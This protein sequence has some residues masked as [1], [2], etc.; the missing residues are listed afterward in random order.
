M[1]TVIIIVTD[2]GSMM[3]TKV[4]N[5]P[6][7]SRHADSSSS[8]G[9]LKE[10]TE[11]EDEQ[12]VLIRKT[13]NGE[14]VERPVSVDHVDRGLAACDVYRVNHTAAEELHDVENVEVSEL[15]EE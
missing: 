4:L 14:N 3:L 2:R 12:S 6:A 10:L 13:C 11:H 5:T 7:P 1:N 9:R 15:H 8:A